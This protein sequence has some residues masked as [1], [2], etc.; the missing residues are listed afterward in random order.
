M[1]ILGVFLYMELQRTSVVSSVNVFGVNRQR[2]Q[3][4]MSIMIRWKL[5]YLCYCKQLFI[6]IQYILQIVAHA[7]LDCLVHHVSVQFNPL[8]S[9]RHTSSLFRNTITKVSKE[10]GMYLGASKANT[11]L[12]QIIYVV[13]NKFRFNV[14][15]ICPKLLHL[16]RSQMH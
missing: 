16:V 15:S 3:Q 5:L 13:W 1:I 8:Q 12:I 9:I 6:F 7:C 10:A 11:Y 14:R 2:R 4:T